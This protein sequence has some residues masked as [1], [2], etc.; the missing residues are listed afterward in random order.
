MSAEEAAAVPGLIRSDNGLD[1]LFCVPGRRR[2][3]AASL[4]PGEQLHRFPVRWF[5]AKELRTW[6][7]TVLMALLLANADLAPTERSRTRV[8]A[9]GIRGVADWLGDTPAVTRGSYIDPRVISRYE[10]EGRLTGIPRLPAVLPAAAEAEVAVA[11]L[12][13]T[14]ADH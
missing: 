7:A 13:A 11:A 5:T 4:A 12:L 3:A 9:S 6:N 2:L 1:P 8:I 14:D 10:S